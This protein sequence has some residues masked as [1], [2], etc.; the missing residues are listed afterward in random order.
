MPN[1]CPQDRCELCNGRNHRAT[2][3]P[4]KCNCNIGSLHNIN[5]CPNLCGCGETPTHLTV[6][7][8]LIKHLTL[9]SEVPMFAT[10]IVLA[11]LLNVWCFTSF[12]FVDRNTLEHSKMISQVYVDSVISTKLRSENSY[13]QIMI[14]GAIL[15]STLYRN[16][17]LR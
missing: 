11:L 4:Q 14:L 7:C 15:P 5:N 12:F 3:C 6:D 17:F 1:D 8:E 2:M 16:L 13:K 10:S 9:L